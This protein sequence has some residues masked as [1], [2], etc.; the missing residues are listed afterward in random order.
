V[1]LHCWFSHLTFKIVLEMTYKVTSGTIS[2][3]S[4]TQWYCPYIC[5]RFAAV[6]VTTY[7]FFYNFQ[8]NTLAFHFQLQHVI[9]LK[10]LY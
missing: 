4:L 7:I 6:L 2:L 10:S 8:S 5:A 9:P 3:N 1:L